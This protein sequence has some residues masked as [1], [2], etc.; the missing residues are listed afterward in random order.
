[1]HPSYG[2]KHSNTKIDT[3]G[4]QAIRTVEILARSRTSIIDMIPKVQGWVWNSQLLIT[5][6]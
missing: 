1:M 6:V 2:N 3:L 4:R 5:T